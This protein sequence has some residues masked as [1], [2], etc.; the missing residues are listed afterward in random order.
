MLNE[1]KAPASPPERKKTFIV[2]EHNQIYNTQQQ[3]A[4]LKAKTTSPREV[5]RV[6]S[7][8]ANTKKFHRRHWNLPQ[9][10]WGNNPMWT[11]TG[12][13]NITHL[14]WWFVWRGHCHL[15]F[16]QQAEEQPHLKII[17]DEGCCHEL[18]NKVVLMP[19]AEGAQMKNYPASKLLPLGGFKY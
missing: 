10:A 7:G 19:T 17:L 1:P 14:V 16:A 6:L 2:R 13:F 8:P 4:T 3:E 11:Y 9:Y 5:P 12:M 15:T 18:W